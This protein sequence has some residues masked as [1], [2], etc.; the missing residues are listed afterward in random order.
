VKTLGCQSALCG[1]ALYVYS[2]GAASEFGPA[3]SAVFAFA[4]SL[5]ANAGV[6]ASMSPLK[7]LITR[8][9]SS[10][11]PSLNDKDLCNLCVQT[12]INHHMGASAVKRGVRRNS[13]GHTLSRRPSRTSVSSGPGK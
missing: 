7:L 8:R 5:R 3:L 4:R 11:Y 2:G 9:R 6:V 13:R 1:A 10:S 12:Q